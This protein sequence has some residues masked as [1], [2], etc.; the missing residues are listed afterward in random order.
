MSKKVSQQPEPTAAQWREKAAAVRA[1]EGELVHLPLG[2]TAV[3]S[4]PP[5]E[6]WWGTDMMPQE[7]TADVQRV[8]GET[9]GDPDRVEEAFN[10]IGEERSGK[11]LI[12]MREIV[13][14]TCVK[15]RIVMNNPNEDEI[16]PGDSPPPAF[17][18]TFARGLP[19]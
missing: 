13:R 19:H 18:P 10:E 7:L 17:A 5:L 16:T 8:F 6:L 1:E 14:A 3:L 15:P 9:E 4:P 12:F 2:F 11:L